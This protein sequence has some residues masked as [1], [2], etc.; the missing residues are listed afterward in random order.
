MLLQAS[1]DRGTQRSIGDGL[2]DQTI[3]GNLRNLNSRQKFVHQFGE[4]WYQ[5]RRRVDERELLGFHQV[6]G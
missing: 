2:F 3:I 4:H 5:D 6:F 1:N